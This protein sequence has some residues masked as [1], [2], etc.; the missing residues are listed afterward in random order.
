MPHIIVEYTNNVPADLP[1]MLDDLHYLLA[2]FDTININA[3]KSRAIPVEYPI[4]GDG[5]ERDQFIHITLKLLE[6]RTEDLRVQMGKA[7][8]EKAA[9]FLPKGS[10]IALSL[11][12]AE[13]NAATYVK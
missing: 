2:E 12:V 11:E 5:K 10:D 7:L 6:G 8:H 4:V 3:I 13:M 1:K 9:S